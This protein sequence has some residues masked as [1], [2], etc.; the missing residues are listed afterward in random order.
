[1]PLK[2]FFDSLVFENVYIHATGTVA[3]LDESKGPIGSY[4]D[5]IHQDYYLGNKTF[6]LAEMQMLEEAVT[7]CLQKLKKS[8]KDIHLYIGGDLNN[9][10][11]TS[12]YIARKFERPFYGI[13]SACSTIA[14]ALQIGGSLIENKQ[15]E[16]A[17]IFVSSHHATAERQFRYPNEYGVQKKITST[18]TATGA[19]S[20][21]L[22][23][24]PSI[25][26]VG[27]ITRGRVIDYEQKNANDMGRCMAPAAFDTLERHL[28]DL[29]IDGDYYDLI[30]TGDLSNYGKQ[31]MIEL[32]ASKNIKYQNYDDCGCILFDHL[33]QDVQMGGSGP[34]CSALVAFGYIYKLMLEKKYQK[35]LFIP[36]G[37]LLSPVMV[38]QKQSIP[39]IAHAFSLE[40]V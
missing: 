31:I 40:V 19:V 34:T 30:L 10:I 22:S 32:M 29:K 39:C 16:N 18:F 28:S 33:K 5:M 37:A 27:S 26:R 7:I 35:V 4:F 6:E 14:E 24:R 38:N 17:N 11:T 12:N 23:S 2:S 20:V 25:I 13:Y 36:T 1:M 3:G 9:Q 21:Y 15:I 8:Y